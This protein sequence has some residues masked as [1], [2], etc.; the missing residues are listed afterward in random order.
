MACIWLTVVWKEAKQDLRHSRAVI[1]AGRI[2]LRQGHWSG[3]KNLTEEFDP[4]SGE[5]IA[6][7]TCVHRRSVGMEG[8][9]GVEKKRLVGISCT[10]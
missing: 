4:C 10:K 6:S 9:G 2:A 1:T 5:R 8:G 7:R 3:W